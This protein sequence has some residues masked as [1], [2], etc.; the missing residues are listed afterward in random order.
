MK[1]KQIVYRD[2][3]GHFISGPHKKSNKYI[4]TISSTFCNSLDELEEIIK[5]W[6]RKHILS[7]NAR[8]FMV[9]KSK[10]Y[11][12]SITMTITYKK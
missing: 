6:E 12:P 7:G 2:D 4:Y 10:M 3:K 11:K 8:I 1:K 9:E 5:G